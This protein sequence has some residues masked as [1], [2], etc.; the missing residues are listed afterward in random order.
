M[1]W[2][3]QYEYSTNELNDD[4]FEGE[5]TRLVDLLIVYRLS[6]RFP[7][8]LEPILIKIIEIYQTSDNEDVM[9]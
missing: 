8:S 2:K 6:A 5:F 3:L 7:I 1:N 4:H 9:W